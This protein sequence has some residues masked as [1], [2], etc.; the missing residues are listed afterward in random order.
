MIEIVKIRCAYLAP[1]EMADINAVFYRN[2]LRALVWRMS[3]MPVTGAG[4]IDDD[5]Q[6][7]AGAFLT[8]G[9][10]GQRRTTD[11]TQ[12]NKQN[13]HTHKNTLI[14]IHKLV[15]STPADEHA[16]SYPSAAFTG[17]IGLQIIRTCVD[18]KGG[19][20]SI[21]Q[22]I[23]SV[24]ERRAANQCFQRTGAVG[25]DIEVEEIAGMRPLRIVE[26]MLLRSRVP[27]A[28]SG[29]EIG[30][31]AFAG[32]V[33]MHTMLAGRH[34][35]RL[36]I[37]QQT[38]IALRDNHFAILC[39]VRTDQCRARNIAADFTRGHTFLTASGNHEGQ[40]GHAR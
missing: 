40:K 30:T 13:R 17:R 5:V 29:F 28:A 18:D 32:L 6:T 12:T 19:A 22:G 7:G 8:E 25:A 3:D 1:P 15:G 27:V 24:A 11:I 4:R 34:A 14:F 9:S 2:R 39:L 20:I 31:Y 38:V 33:D 35:L 21:K 23:F 36:D 10:F 37:D 16:A 26:S